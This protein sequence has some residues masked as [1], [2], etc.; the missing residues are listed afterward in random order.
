VAGQILQHHECLDGSG[1]P[2]G[3]K[4]DALGE[5]ARVLAAVSALVWQTEA[6]GYRPGRTPEAALAALRAPTLAAKYEERILAALQA[7]I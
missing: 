1:F 4:G 7:S 6:V 2:S 5:T 3:L